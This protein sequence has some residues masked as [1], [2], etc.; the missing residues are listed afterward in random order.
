M[1]SDSQAVVRHAGQALP[2]LRQVSHGQP[3]GNQ[4]GVGQTIAGGDFAVD[5]SLE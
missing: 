4:L 3:N 5:D 1:P 2:Q